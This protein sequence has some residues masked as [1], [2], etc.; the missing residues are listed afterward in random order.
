MRGVVSLTSSAARRHG[1]IRSRRMAAVGIRCSSSSTGARSAFDSLPIL[2]LPDQQPQEEHDFASKLRHA[3]HNVGFFY[4]RNHGVSTQTYANALQSSKDFFALDYEQKMTIDY[5]QSP[6]FRGYMAQ[7]LENTAGRPDRREQI[8]FGV[9]PP[10]SETSASSSTSSST[11]STMR[12]YYK[13]LVAHPNQWPDQHVPTLRPHVQQFMKE[14]EVLSRRLMTYLALSLDLPAGNFDDTFRTCPNVQLKICH[15]PAV[16]STHNNNSNNG[17][18]GNDDDTRAMFGVGPHTDSGYLSLLL[19]DDVGGLQVQNGE[20]KWIDAPPIDG[21]IVVNL[22]EMLQLA[23][24]GY[25]LATPHRVLNV[26]RQHKNGGRFSVP[27]F[28]NPRLDFCMERIEL[29]KSLVWERP[30]PSADSIES[31]DSHDGGNKLHACYGE[32]AFKSLARSHPQ[33]MERHHPDLIVL[34]DGTIEEKNV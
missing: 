7:G 28:W 10:T 16:T 15:Y 4:V 18:G 5:R 30:K 19:Q 8:E 20:G 22:G 2:D 27:Y 14:M 33:V 21:T 1:R 13:R 34:P 25:F 17:D 12:P 23:T 9:D 11:T 24:R 32:N 6:A 29:P 3:C 26:E 31:T